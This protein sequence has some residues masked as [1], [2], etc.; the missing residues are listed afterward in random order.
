M[1][2]K[3]LKAA[4]W[5]KKNGFSVIPV[6]P[7]KKPFISWTRYQKERASEDQIKSWWTKWPDANIGLCCGKISEVD[8]IDCDSQAGVDALNEFLSDSFLTPMAQTPKGYH[9]YFKHRPGLSNGVRVLTDCDLRTT[10]GYII[11]PPSTNGNGKDYQWKIKISDE[12]PADMPP[13]LFDVLKQGTS[14]ALVND[15]SLYIYRDV[16]NPTPQETT[17]TTGDHRFFVKGRRDEDLFSAANCLIKGGANPGFALQVLDKI[18]QTLGND[19]T[20][21]EAKEK[22]LSVLKRAEARERN[23]AAEI[24]DW[25]LTTS[26]HFLTTDYHRDL[27]LTTRDHKKAATMAILRLVDK[28]VLEKHGDRRGCYRVAEQTE[29]EDWMNARIDTLNIRLPFGLDEYVKVFP[30][31]VFVIAGVKS[32]GKTTV[33]FNFM[34]LNMD[35]FACYYHSSEL[36]K[37]TFR[38]RVSKCRDTKLEDWKTVKMSK[39]LSMINAKDRT[40]PGALNVFDYIESEEGE[41]YKIPGTI[42]KIH[43]AL[44]DGVAIVCLQKPSNR[45]TARG[46]EGTKDKANL[47]LTIDKEY[48][49]HVLRVQECKTFKDQNPEGFIIKYKIVDGINIFPKGNLEPEMER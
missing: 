38:L 4:L 44:G 41:F 19:F 9:F 10:G 18:T 32:A 13:M 24:E 7:N 20:G 49:Y 27:D 26:G 2:N 3:K 11:A 22:L 39:G 46:G 40:V 31:D 21:K 34:K 25:V 15:N 42:A 37:Q 8:V 35:N 48:P 1:E 29:Y 36:V 6:K 16:V 47:Y 23:I 12:P 14:N 45:D 33:A 5:Y 30:G 17:L 43:R 28:G